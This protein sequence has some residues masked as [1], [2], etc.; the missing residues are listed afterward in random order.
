M[1]ALEAPW[2]WQLKD[3]VD[4]TWM[5]GYSTHLP[6]MEEEAPPAS[7]AAKAAGGE[8][9]D[10]LAKTSMRC[11]GCGAKVGATV[12][13]RVMERIREQGHV[14]NGPDGAVLLGPRSTV[15]VAVFV[16]P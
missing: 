3:W 5:S 8:A 12:L 16:G 2:L 7:L 1:L 4:R 6:E 9:L 10:A 11:G 14:H 13:S 15:K